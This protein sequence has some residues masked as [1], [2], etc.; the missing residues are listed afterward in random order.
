MKEQL[1]ELKARAYDMLAFIQ[2][3]QKELGNLNQQIAEVSAR[4]QE[5]AD[6]TKPTELGEKKEKV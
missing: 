1:Q 3:A 4:E 5:M 6:G 2:S